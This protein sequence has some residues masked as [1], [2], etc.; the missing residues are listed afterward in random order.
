M[1]LFAAPFFLLCSGHSQLDCS[2]HIY[3]IIYESSRPLELCDCIWVHILFVQLSK[4][5]YLLIFVNCN[6]CWLHQLMTPS[7]F[8]PYAENVAQNVHKKQSCFWKGM[9]LRALTFLSV[10]YSNSFCQIKP[11]CSL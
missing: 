1:T 6:I 4:L 7:A 3:Q 5:V 9:P 11:L 10:S 8:L 2:E